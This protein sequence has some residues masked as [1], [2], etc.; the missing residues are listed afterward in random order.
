[1]AIT[2][3]EN[4]VTWPTSATDKAVA[5]GTAE[6]SEEVTLDDTCVA[7]SITVKANNT[8]TPA[9][10]DTVDFYWAATGGEP[11]VDPSVTD[12]FPTQS[13]AHWLCR[14]DTNLSGNNPG[15]KTV[16]LPAVPKTGKVIADNNS[17]GRSITCS[18]TIEEIRAA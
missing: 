14:I 4:Q 9:S 11:D 16:D 5:S 17:S 8:G 1:M 12:D 7:A 2:R 15:V 10:G 18:A 6:T 13:D 3:A